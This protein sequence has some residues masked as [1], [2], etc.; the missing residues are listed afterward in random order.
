M[1]GDTGQ[2]SEVVGLTPAAGLLW[3]LLVRTLFNTAS[4]LAARLYLLL[5]AWRQLLPGPPPLVLS[6]GLVRISVFSW[7]LPVKASEHFASIN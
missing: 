6:Q 4:E 3:T 7:G 5:P 1:H 2:V